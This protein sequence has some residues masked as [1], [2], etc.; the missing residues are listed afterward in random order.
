MYQNLSKANNHYSTIVRNATYFEAII[1][2]FTCTFL[3]EKVSY[4]LPRKPWPEK[5]EKKAGK[6]KK[7]P[8]KYLT[9]IENDNY[10]A[11]EIDPV[12]GIKVYSLLTRGTWI[13]CLVYKRWEPKRRS[14]T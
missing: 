4:E 13:E 8:E 5:E 10:T 7:P 3:V 2:K 12:N 11:Y 1:H 9:I 6:R 14:E